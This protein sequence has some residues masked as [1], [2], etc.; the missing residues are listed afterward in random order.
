MFLSY[1]LPCCGLFLSIYSK[2]FIGTFI[3]FYNIWREKVL[4]NSRDL[5]DRLTECPKRTIITS[6]LGFVASQA[7]PKWL[8]NSAF[9]FIRIFHLMK[10]WLFLLLTRQQSKCQNKRNSIRAK[11]QFFG[12]LLYVW[13]QLVQPFSCCRLRALVWMVTCCKEHLWNNLYGHI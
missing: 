5:L 6:P 7:N 9:K 3:I 13:Y 10:I 8:N 12:Q 1:Y 4:H 2:L 11:V